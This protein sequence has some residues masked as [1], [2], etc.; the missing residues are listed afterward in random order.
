LVEFALVLPVL[1]MFLFGIVQF[2]IAYDKQQSLNA[3]ARE[4]A[5][6][7]SL[8]VTDLEEIAERAVAAADMSAV[9]NDPLV[10]VADAAGTVVGVRCPGGAFSKTE[11]CSS[12]VAIDQNDETLMP[13]G[14]TPAAQHVRVRV[15]NPYRIT[16]PFFDFGVVDIDAEA[17]F[18][19]E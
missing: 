15:S 2:G 16:F 6:L 3:A 5:R 8:R 4:G 9:G 17:Q 18:R 12:P 7:A 14:K 10:V 13:C 11:S 19:C 1:T